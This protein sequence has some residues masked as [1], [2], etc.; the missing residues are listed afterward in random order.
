MIYIWYNPTL[1]TYQLGALKDFKSL[2]NREE[3]QK[4]FLLLYKF[5]KNKT[6]LAS[7]ILGQLNSNQNEE[8]NSTEENTFIGYIE[9]KRC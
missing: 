3:D 6:W 9:P 4:D 7:K 1:K 2:R 5:A 8:N